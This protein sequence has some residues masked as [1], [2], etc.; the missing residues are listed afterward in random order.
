MPP[1]Q[2]RKAIALEALNQETCAPLCEFRMRSREHVLR[3]HGMESAVSAVARAMKWQVHIEGQMNVHG[4]RKKR[5]HAERKSHDE[6]KKIKI[7]PEHRAP[8]QQNFYRA[9]NA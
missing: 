5:K 2:A 3:R 8:P 9:F 6:T 7:G 1:N 4:A